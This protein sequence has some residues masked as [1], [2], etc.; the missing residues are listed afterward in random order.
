MMKNPAPNSICHESSGLGPQSGR[1]RGPDDI[2]PD[3]TIEA[4][5]G[6]IPPASRPAV[7]SDDVD[8]I[9]NKYPSQMKI[10]AS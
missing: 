3:G 5:H 9:N 2:D 8:R 1:R 10:A 7:T 4:L 6:F